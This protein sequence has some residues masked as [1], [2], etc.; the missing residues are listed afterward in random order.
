MVTLT[1]TAVSVLAGFRLWK[2]Y[3]PASV[4]FAKASLWAI[5]AGM[6]LLGMLLTWAF[7][8]ILPVGDVLGILKG[9]VLAAVCSAYLGRSWRVRNTYRPWLAVRA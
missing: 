1:A 9:V 3:L 7:Y 4:R 5:G 8:R 6:P 2:V